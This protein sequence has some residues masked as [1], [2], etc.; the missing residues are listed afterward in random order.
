MNERM[1][2]L[3]RSTM[4]KLE[5]EQKK[6]LKGKRFLLLRNEERVSAQYRQTGRH[7]QTRTNRAPALV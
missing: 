5:D 1:N 3:R 2:N 6:E 7:L 4:N